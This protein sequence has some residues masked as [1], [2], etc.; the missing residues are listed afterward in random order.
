MMHRLDG[1]WR[2]ALAPAC[3]LS[4][5]HFF[6]SAKAIRCIILTDRQLAGGG[7]KFVKLGTYC[8]NILQTT[9][10]SVPHWYLGLG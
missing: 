2:F 8:M 3:E 1:F 7:G 10:Q 9:I 5:G 6:D 4:C